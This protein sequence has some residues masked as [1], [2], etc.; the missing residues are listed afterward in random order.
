MNA[1]LIPWTGSSL[2]LCATAGAL[3]WAMRNLQSF[4]VPE[5][6]PPAAATV[7]SPNAEGDNSAWE[8]VRRPAVYYAA[9]TDRPLFAPMRRPTPPDSGQVEVLPQA[10]AEPVADLPAE[11]VVPVLTL[12]G[13]MAMTDGGSA[14][15]GAEDQPPEWVA[16]GGNIAGFTL[17]TVG[18]DWAQLSSS[19]TEL[20]L[21]LYPK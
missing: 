8:S 16:V 13:T 14:L 9:I 21:D 11:A 5:I 18:P 12:H 2:L 15:I 4:E 6:P 17:N 20:K 19:K 3:Y 10:D 1:R 7:P